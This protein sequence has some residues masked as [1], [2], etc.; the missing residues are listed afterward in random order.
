MKVF[1]YSYRD[2]EKPCYAGLAESLDVELDFCHD[3]PSVENAVLAKGAQAVSIVNTP[4]TKDI[5]QAL[6]D[7]GVRYIST[8][9]IG[10][11][12][13][14]MDAAKEIGM[15]VGNSSYA[16]NGVAEFSV[17]LI[18]MCA[19]NASLIVT[20][21]K[22]QNY[23]LNGKMGRLLRDSTVG[24]IGTGKIGAQVIKILTGFGCKIL[25]YDL[26]PK[27]ELKDI[28]EYT[29]L[30]TLFKNSD[31][32][33]L[34]APSTKENYHLINKETIAMMKDGVIITNTAR[35]S[36]I[37]TDAL[38]EGLESGKIAGA[39]LDVLENETD[40]YH[41]NFEGQPAPME[42]IAKL[43]EFPNVVLTPHTAFFTNNALVEMIRNSI[44]T[45]AAEL[46]G[47]PNPSKVL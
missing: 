38:I 21:F 27:D 31:I 33:T 3:A 8:R 32:I 7:Q 39:G 13:I 19:R 11:D 25:A 29:D 26:Y 14:D 41:N 18:M 45:C 30:E 37:D 6:Y 15:S 10:Y 2:L 40:I 9:N 46:K 16:P 28:V 4:V 42:A 12:H 20:D 5:I 43:N 24:V 1:V 47:E 23:T 34:H 44:I 35:G 22:K 36:L 17:M